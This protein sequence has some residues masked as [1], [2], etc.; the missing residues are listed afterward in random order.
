MPP[1][2]IKIAKEDFD[3]NKSSIRN[4]SPCLPLLPSSHLPL[5]LKSPLTVVSSRTPSAVLG[6][7]DSSRTTLQ[8][9][10]L[11]FSGNG[12]HSEYQV[13]PL[14]LA[15][16]GLVFSNPIQDATSSMMSCNDANHSLG[17]PAQLTATVA[18]G[19]P[20]TAYWNQV[21]PHNIGP[22]VRVEWGL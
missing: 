13:L 19:T 16:K 11:P 22:M 3:W 21:W 1:S 12:T 4:S 5:F 14:V 2:Y 10:R 6:T 17:S 20:I 9:A 7:K 15:D 8:L 18:A